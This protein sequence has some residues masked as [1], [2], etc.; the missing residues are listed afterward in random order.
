MH[1]HLVVRLPPGQ[2]RRSPRRRR[3]PGNGETLFHLG[4]P[5]FCRKENNRRMGIDSCNSSKFV[6][7]P[8]FGKVVWTACQ[9]ELIQM[10]GLS[11]H[12]PLLELG[13]NL[14]PPTRLPPPGILPAGSVPRII[15]SHIILA[16]ERA[17]SS[18]LWYVP[19]FH[20]LVIRIFDISM[21]GFYTV[22]L[23]FMRRRN[24]VFV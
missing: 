8:P 7:R 13:A 22:K 19:L 18:F 21:P 20:F 4:E 24:T 2:D 23:I 17:L 1:R 10:R 5:T 9:D 12:P 16:P 3:T 6:I 14:H 11:F 15:Q